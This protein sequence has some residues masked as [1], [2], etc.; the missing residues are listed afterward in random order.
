MALSR[1]QFLRSGT[2]ASSLLILPRGL[3]AQSPVSPNA[4]LQIALIGVGGRG[5]APLT[6]LQD[7]QIVAF[8]DVDHDRARAEVGQQKKATTGLFDRFSQ[9]G[10]PDRRGLGLG[11]YIARCIVEAHGGRIWAVSQLGKGSAFHF[12]I[13][14]TRPS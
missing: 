10:H 3:R 14:N 7:E 2:F 1:R 6:A 11:L 12:T 13:P 4:R 8:C 9:A 5:R